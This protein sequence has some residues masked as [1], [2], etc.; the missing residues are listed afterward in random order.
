MGREHEDGGGKIYGDSEATASERACYPSKRITNR[1]MHNDSPRERIRSAPAR[2]ILETGDLTPEDFSQFFERVWNPRRDPCRIA[3][4]RSLAQ[5]A[6]METDVPYPPRTREDEY[7]LGI[8]VWEH[9]VKHQPYLDYLLAGCTF[10]GVDRRAGGQDEEQMLRLSSSFQERPGHPIDA[11]T[12]LTLAVEGERVAVYEHLAQ[13]G[14][15]LRRYGQPREEAPAPLCWLSPRQLDGWV[16]L[17][18][19]LS[20]W[21]SQSRPLPESLSSFADF[22]LSH[23]PLRYANNTQT[24]ALFNACMEEKQRETRGSERTYVIEHARNALERF[25]E[26]E[27][28]QAFLRTADQNTLTRLAASGRERFGPSFDTFI[29]MAQSRGAANPYGPDVLLFEAGLFPLDTP[30]HPAL[31]LK[32]VPLEEGRW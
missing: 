30:T 17:P 3:E 13:A 21:R 18:K 9:L 27:K 5:D 32:G 2:S 31:I 14:S 23:D 22:S 8:A 4:M 25:L 24:R 6:V 11:E 26:W 28:C 29:Q 19:T 15:G 12:A 16:S 1:M 20:E 10:E 7:A